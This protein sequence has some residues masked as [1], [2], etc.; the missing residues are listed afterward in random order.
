MEL[1]LIHINDK[2]STKCI[3]KND[4]KKNNISEA[5]TESSNATDTLAVLA[6]LINL[7]QADNMEVKKLFDSFANVKAKNETHEFTNR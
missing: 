5:L 7:Q 6:V 4:C 3:S 2:Y 1:Q